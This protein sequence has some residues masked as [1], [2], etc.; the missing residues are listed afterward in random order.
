MADMKPGAG[1]NPVDREPAWIKRV[2]DADGVL[3]VEL[4]GELDISSTPTIRTRFT[5]L[6]DAAPGR[7]VVDARELR[8]IDSSGIA[9][10]LLAAQRVAAV[11]IVHPRPIVRRV[12]EVSG[13]AEVLRIAT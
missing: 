10:L 13:L 2:A 8:F 7:L 6:L 3:H 12:I 1:G 4:G 9:L 5:E 11:E